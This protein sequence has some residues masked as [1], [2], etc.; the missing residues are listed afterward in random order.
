M[1]LDYID[2]FDSKEI[3]KIICKNTKIL[4]IKLKSENLNNNI[5]IKKKD[6]NINVVQ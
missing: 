1:M 3:C 4:N 2:D 5:S 6:S